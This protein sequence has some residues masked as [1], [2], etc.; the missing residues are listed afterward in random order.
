MSPDP[1]RLVSSQEQGLGKQKQPQD[2]ART[3]ND[4]GKTQP[5]GGHLQ[6]E[7]K[8]LEQTPSMS[9]LETHPVVGGTSLLDSSHQDREELNP[10]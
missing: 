9:S 5:E 2:C 10:C 8:S 3:A 1:V 6:V 7:K 4:H